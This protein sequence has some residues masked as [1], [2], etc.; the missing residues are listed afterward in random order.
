MTWDLVE[1]RL[2]SHRYDG[3]R[4]EAQQPALIMPAS[5][6]ERS[7]L[8]EVRLSAYLEDTDAD[9]V[10]ATEPGLSVGLARMGS[11]RYLRV[12]HQHVGYSMQPSEL[13]EEIKRWYGNLDAVV[14]VSRRDTEQL[15]TALLRCDTVVR[16]IPRC[17]PAARLPP[18]HGTSRIVMAA[19]RLEPAKQYDRLIR[20]FAEIATQ[21]P[22]WSLRIHGDG[23]ERQRL[24]SVIDSLGLSNRIFLMGASGSMESEWVKASI[25]VCS[26][27]AEP[28]ATPLLEAM[29]AGVPVVSFDCDF[30]PREVLTDGQNGLLVTADDT[31]A[32]SDALAS[33]MSGDAERKEMGARSRASIG[34]FAPEQVV[35][36]YEELVEAL[37]IRRALPVTAD[38]RV[39][40]RGD[41][42][43]RVTSASPEQASDLTLLCRAS[44]D[45]SDHEVRI[46]LRV[47]PTHPDAPE[48]PSKPAAVIPAVEGPLDEGD[49]EVHVESTCTGMR[50]R[51]R[52]GLYDT[53]NLLDIAGPRTSRPALQ[54]QTPHTTNDGYLAIRVRTREVH[55][56]A[57]DINVEN[58]RI[59]VN[60]QLWGTTAETPPT[61]IAQGRQRSSQD[62]DIAAE[63]LAPDRFRFTV[64]CTLPASR[65][66]TEHDN[67]DLWVRLVDGDPVRIARFAT[68]H[69]DIKSTLRYPITILEETPRGRSRVRP[70][71]TVNGELA[72]NA[73]DMPAADPGSSADPPGGSPSASGP[74]R[75]AVRVDGKE[76]R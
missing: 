50:R 19:G 52:T 28:F 2:T 12:A 53:R 42:A 21:H 62:F 37:R 22:G 61:I 65:R 56:E 60:V 7:R 44:K 76:D 74:W 45:G 1:K 59:M 11:D 14:S 4:P 73:V 23:P 31:Q 27:R 5:D 58:G 57:G 55:A 8:T 68:D 66:V 20:A 16:H 9:V 69:A 32:L 64:P 25:A 15:Q 30:G 70:Y 10:I 47:P 48:T 46:P 35:A 34:R 40:P 39:T 54:I 51:L 71:Y 36:R 13:R 63:L 17:L 29:R 41:I 24:L 38:W 6:T 67:W 26:S 43:V 18:S 49:W 75:P 33:L 3:D 72:L